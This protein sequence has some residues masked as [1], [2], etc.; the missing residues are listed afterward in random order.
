MHMLVSLKYLAYSKHLAWNL[1]NKDD[2]NIGLEFDE[3]F[4][5]PS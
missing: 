5:K 3:S 1:D 4:F 2:S